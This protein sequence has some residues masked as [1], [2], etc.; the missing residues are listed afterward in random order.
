V[1]NKGLRIGH[2]GPETTS[3]RLQRFICF[4]AVIS[5]LTSSTCIAPSAGAGAASS[6]ETPALSLHRTVLAALLRSLRPLR[7]TSRSCSAAPS[8]YFHCHPLASLPFR[9]RGS[10][11]ILHG[12]VLGSIFCSSTGT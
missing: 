5:V 10:F 8:P 4:N 2:Q 11:L 6:S 7:S 1:Q 3:L 12:V 9:W